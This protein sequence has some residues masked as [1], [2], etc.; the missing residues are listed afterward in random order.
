MWRSSRAGGTRPCAFRVASPDVRRAWGARFRM[1]L[2]WRS[3]HITVLVPPVRTAR[4]YNWSEEAG[5]FD[6]V[7]RR[8]VQLERMDGGLQVLGSSRSDQDRCYARVSEDPRVGEGCHLGPV[9]ACVVAQ[10]VESLPDIRA[11]EVPVGVRTHAH[12]RGGR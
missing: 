11:V 7:R 6:A 5:D 9:V 10:A 2:A 12:P 8:E 1:T 4:E 3:H